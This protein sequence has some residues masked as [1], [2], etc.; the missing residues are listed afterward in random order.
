MT[1]LY[2]NQWQ[3][4]FYKR[5]KLTKNYTLFYNN[6]LVSAFTGNVENGFKKL[7]HSELRLWFY[8]YI[9]CREG[10]IELDYKEINK[11]TGITTNRF[12]EAIRGLVNKGYLVAKD[13]MS[14]LHFYAVALY[15][16]PENYNKQDYVYIGDKNYPKEGAENFTALSNLILL[17]KIKDLS[18]PSLKLYLYFVIFSFKKT[19]NLSNKDVCKKTGLGES[20]YNKAIHELIDRGFL[21]L[22]GNNRYLFVEVPNENNISE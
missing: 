14:Q 1:T 20:S 4:H 15:P 13:R 6:T 22:T 9:Y 2:A 21:V 8:L 19:F 16:Q 12:Y 7:T 11:K 3:I 5:E 17:D 18:F 10:G